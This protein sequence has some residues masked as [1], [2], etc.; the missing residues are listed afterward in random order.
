MKFIPIILVFSLVIFVL[1][2]GCVQS[3]QS[4]DLNDKNDLVVVNISDN[5]VPLVEDLVVVDKTETV[6]E[7]VNLCETKDCND[8]SIFTIDSCVIS[9]HKAIC[10]N[11]RI[12]SGPNNGICEVEE[13]ETCDIKSGGWVDGPNGKVTGPAWCCPQLAHPVISKTIDSP[14]C[15]E[16][17]NDNNELTGDYYDFDNQKCEHYNC[18]EFS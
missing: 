16:S 2:S 1:F 12:P 10:L 7:D 15:P 6:I 14:D 9:Y 17:C 3:I 13:I 11:E 8:G 18:Q 4:Q 5:N